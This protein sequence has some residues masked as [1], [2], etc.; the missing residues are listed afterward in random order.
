MKKI[1]LTVTGKTV[2]D[3]LVIGNVFQFV[4]TLGL[5]LSVVYDHLLNKGMVIDWD[6][7]VNDAVN[8][9]W[10]P[11]TIES[12]CLDAMR[13]HYEKKTFGKYLSNK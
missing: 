9:K 12:R 1:H 13:F 11:N 5:P 10:N 8:A 2:T 3:K 6:E 4:D 7:F